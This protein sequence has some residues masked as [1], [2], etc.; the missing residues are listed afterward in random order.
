[1]AIIL[2]FNYTDPDVTHTWLEEDK[3]SGSSAAFANGSQDD[4]LESI[5]KQHCPHGDF[6]A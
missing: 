5:S 1:L 6:S 3:I 4:V 2:P